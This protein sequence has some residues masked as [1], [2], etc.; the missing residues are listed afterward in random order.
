MLCGTEVP[1]AIHCDLVCTKK[2]ADVLHNECHDQVDL[3]YGAC[4]LASSRPEM[5]EGR[6]DMQTWHKIPGDLLQ[7]VC[8]STCRLVYIDGQSRDHPTLRYLW[9]LISSGCS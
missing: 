4:I 9:L 7:I 8:S 5:Q 1:V 6:S 3:A 2:P